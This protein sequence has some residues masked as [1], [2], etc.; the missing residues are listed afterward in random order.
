V[1]SKILESFGVLIKSRAREI[2]MWTWFTVVAC[3][4]VSSGFPPLIPTAIAALSMFLISTSV[5][6]YNDVVDREL[7]KINPYKDHRPLASNRVS[8]QE[9]MILVYSSAVLGLGVSL[10]LNIQSFFIALT[11]LALYTLYSYPR[12]HLKNK[13]I[14]K[15]L[16]LSS[17]HIIMS[18]IGSYGVTGAF[19]DRAFFSSILFTVLTF[20]FIPALNDTTDVEADKQFGYISIAIVLSWRRRM[21]LLFSGLLIVMTLTPFTYANFG[22]NAILPIFVVAGG[23]IFIRYMFPIMNTMEEAK[24]LQARKVG[25]L[26]FILMNIFTVIASL[27]ITNLI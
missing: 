5:Y 20:A 17:G 2:I 10:L 7:D 11:Y 24:F 21:Q 16:I 9:A 4:I 3:M 15:E 13:F 18:L 8:E 12:V 22:F 26:Y 14:V 1:S 25:Y 6:I 19:S 23:L 27:N